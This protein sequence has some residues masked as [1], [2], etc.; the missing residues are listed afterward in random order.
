MFAYLGR[1]AGLHYHKS[2]LVAVGALVGIIT[3]A[4][5]L[6]IMLRRMMGDSR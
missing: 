3:G 2:W 4:S 5:G 6:V 1:L